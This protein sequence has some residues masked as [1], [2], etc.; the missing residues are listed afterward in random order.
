MILQ[1]L[2][3]E[4]H[5]TLIV[6][7][8]S[9][10]GLRRLRSLDGSQDLLIALA[11]LRFL[12]L[13]DV[14]HVS[15]DLLGAG[16]RI[17]GVISAA[18]VEVEDLGPLSENRLRCEC[19]VDGEASTAGPLPSGLSGPTGANFEETASVRLRDLVRA[20]CEDNRSYVVRLECLHHLL[21]HN[22]AGHVG[23][24]VRCDGVDEDV[25]LFAFSC[26]STREPEDTTLGGSVVGLPEVA[27]DTRGGG[28]VDDTAILLLQHVR[29]RSLADLVCAAKVDIKDLMELLVVHVGECLVAQ[30]TGVVD[31][32]VDTAESI[33]RSLYHSVTV[34]ST[35]LD[36]DCLASKLLNLLDSVVGVDQIV[37]NNLG[38][39]LCELKSVDA[40]K[41]STS[42]RDQRNLSL[43]VYF[44]R[45]GVFGQ[46]LRLLKERHEVC[47]TSGVA[48][49]REVGN[50]VPLLQ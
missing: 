34:L 24:C 50:A 9:A 26:Q 5:I 48:G 32:N 49:R 27:V 42:A 21:R 33:D 12:L 35:G 29:P 25:V 40:S 20:E 11:A 30:D 19:N 36:A 18:V 10:L 44:L 23:A 7:E 17:L 46:L 3:V 15:H 1:G 45:L 8:V 22:G 47:Y 28:G 13:R 41:T 4:D 2:T 39:V 16:G 38:A 14:A 37:D 6:C 43:V 31:D